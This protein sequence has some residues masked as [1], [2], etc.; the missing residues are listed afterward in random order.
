MSDSFCAFVQA[1]GVTSAQE[2]SHHQRPLLSP[3]WLNSHSCTFAE[4][5]EIAKEQLPL[6]IVAERLTRH[7][8]ENLPASFIHRHSSNRHRE[9]THQADKS[10]IVLRLLQQQK[11]WGN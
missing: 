10:R 11:P 1:P 4:L 6:H 7:K 2:L 8:E 9:Q 5:L 3:V